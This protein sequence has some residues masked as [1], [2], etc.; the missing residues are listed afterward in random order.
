MK[1]HFG[2]EV[3]TSESNWHHYMSRIKEKRML[4]PLLTWID[5]ILSGPLATRF[6]R[7]LHLISQKASG[8]EVPFLTATAPAEDPPLKRPA[9]SCQMPI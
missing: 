8:C 1:K 2:E 7:S 9:S 3:I 4:F 5:R 6:M